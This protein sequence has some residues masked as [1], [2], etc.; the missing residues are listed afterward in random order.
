MPKSFVAKHIE[1]LPF[2]GIRRVFE[3]AAKFEAAGNKVIHFE[4]GRP[5][6]DTP[7]HIK[8]AAKDALDRGMVHYAPNMGILSLRENLSDNIEELKGVR[9]NPQTELLITAGGQ[10]AMCLCLQAILDPGDEILVPNPGFS[11]FFS[12]TEL[13][14]GI[15]VSMPL[16][17]NENFFPDLDKVKELVSSRT[18]AIIINSPHNPTGGV[19]TMTQMEQI[20]GFAKEHDLIVF[21]DDAY[22]RILYEGKKFIS[23]ASLPDMKDRT[24]IWGSLSKTY[25]MTGWRIGYLAGP[26][27]FI[28]AAVKVQQN[29]MLSV[30]TFAQAGAAFGLKAPQDLVDEMVAEFDIR[31]KFILDAI[32]EI[33]G[34]NCPTEPLGAF[35]VFFKHEV[36]G[37]NSMAVAD[38]MLEKAGVAVVPGT[39]FGDKGEGFLR[40]SYSTSLED[41]REGMDRINQVMSDLING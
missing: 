8:D 30:C 27:E 21:S 17:A 4:I 2:A 3:K 10:E 7:V 13:A 26:E 33:P 34:L 15:P 38:A 20:C 1:K 36:P 22:D 37:L 39:A 23:S 32:N 16:V 35:Y 9:Y 24:I 18:K 6:F 5:D 12:C 40:I 41:C 19:Y 11:Q 28:R 31:R 14:G 29:I 25:A